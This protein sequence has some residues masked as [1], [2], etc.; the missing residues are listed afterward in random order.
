MHRGSVVGL[1][2]K[3]HPAIRRSVYEAGRE[4]PVFTTGSL[5]F[6]IVICNDSNFAEPAHAMAARGATALF[7]PTNNGLPPMKGGAT[8]VAE[9]RQ[10]DIATARANGL[11]VIRADVAGRD[12]DRIS[13]GCSAIVAPDG[14]VVQSAR[15]LS[16]DLI[17][18]DIDTSVRRRHA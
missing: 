8:L 13:F 2:R 18:A 7:V 15:E 3:R 17:V 6:G 9:A 16:E 5:T 11:W 12:T 10:V 4:L 14:T 1:Y